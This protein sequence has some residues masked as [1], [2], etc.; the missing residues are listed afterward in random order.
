MST[1]NSDVLDAA[2]GAATASLGRTRTIDDRLTLL[3]VRAVCISFSFFFASF[4]FALVYLQLINQG[5][6]WRPSSV[7]HPATA[8]GVAEVA[9]ILVSGL[10]YFWGQWTGLYRRNHART[11]LALAVAGLLGLV[12]VVLHIA[13][14]HRPGF[15]LQEG[16]YAS[17]FVGIEGVYTAFLV[18]AVVILLGLTNRSRL[19][20]FDENGAA[21]DAFGEFW[22]W[23]SAIALLNF[24]ALYVQPFFPIS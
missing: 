9:L 5:G 3:A 12:A 13:E 16:G 18:V 14:L 20:R 19:G 15:S 8:L 7:N 2:A 1:S 23:M 11:T 6:L 17:V 24:L 4:Y 21:I 22:G 10:V